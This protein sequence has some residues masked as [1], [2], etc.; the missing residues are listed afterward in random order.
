MERENWPVLKSYPYY[1]RYLQTT[2]D[3]SLR[4][5]GIE[6]RF[7]QPYLGKAL[8][9]AIKESVKLLQ[10]AA[11]SHSKRTSN[12]IHVNVQDFSEEDLNRLHSNYMLL[13]PTLFRM[14]DYGYARQHG[15]YCVPH[16]KYLQAFKYLE[17]PSGF[18]LFYLPKYLAMGFNREFG[19]VEFRMYEST[20][21]LAQILRDVNIALELVE[22]SKQ[23]VTLKENY[24][25]LPELFPRMFQEIKK[26]LVRVKPKTMETF[27]YEACR[28]LEDEL[29]IRA[30]PQRVAVKKPA[31]TPI[32]FNGI[33][34]MEIVT[35]TYTME[36]M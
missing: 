17:K 24:N 15:T 4:E 16:H 1:V 14:T 18:Q 2:K 27:D 7:R 11:P 21:S 20:D 33:E 36:Q 6:I 5:N 30:E 29:R 34:M 31:Y 10:W 19:S 28:R 32:D 3:G 12:H 35:P 25:N 26:C 9:D 8:A 22:Y 13:E 23:G